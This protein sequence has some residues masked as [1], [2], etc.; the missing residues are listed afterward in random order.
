MNVREYL[1]L[2]HYWCQAPLASIDAEEAERKADE[3]YRTLMK[4]RGRGWMALTRTAS[5]SKRVE[6]V[7]DFSSCSGSVLGVAGSLQG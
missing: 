5:C 3:L 4:V 6:P 2:A 7:I 1:E